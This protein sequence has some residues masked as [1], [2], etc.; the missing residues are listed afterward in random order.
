M[1]GPAT[2]RLWFPGHVHPAEVCLGRLSCWGVGRHWQ[3]AMTTVL[4]RPRITEYM[5]LGL[6]YRGVCVPEAA[7]LRWHGLQEHALVVVD[8]RHACAV[9]VPERRVG[10]RVL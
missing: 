10:G 4:L 9:I 8:D 6:G 5:W 3:H 2:I 1:H 7:V